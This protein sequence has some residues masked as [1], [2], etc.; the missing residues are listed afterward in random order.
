MIPSSTDSRIL[1]FAGRSG[2]GKGTQAVFLNRDFNIPIIKTG[3][4]L[5]ERAEKNDYTGRNLKRGFE[6]GFLVPT[7]LVFELWVEEFDAIKKDPKFAGFIM[8]GNPRKLY[9]A[10]LLEELFEWYHWGNVILVHI[11]ITAKEAMKRMKE[12]RRL[13]DTQEEMEHKES[14]YQTD[15][16]PVLEYFASKD[17]RIDVNG[18]QSEEKVYEE[19]KKKLGL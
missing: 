11:D 9:E 14:W 16:V 8:D 15:V 1:L 13:G 2:C 19:L 7:P 12:R 18:E 5:R 17:Q 10:H 4:L 3:R 6:K